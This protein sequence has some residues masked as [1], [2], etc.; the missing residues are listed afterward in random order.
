[1]RHAR[2]AAGGDANATTIEFR[3]IIPAPPR[4]AADDKTGT[5]R[6]ADIEIS[7]IS[8]EADLAAAFDIRREVFC[9]EQGVSEEEEID[10]LDAECR[11]Y[12]VRTGD[13]AVATARTRTI[14]SGETKIE[15]VAVLAAYRRC[16][17]GRALMECVISDIGKSPMTLNAQ[18]R[19][20][21]FYAR[22]GFVAEGEIFDEAGI[23]H[24]RM[25]LRTI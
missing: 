21:E 24:R 13:L 6:V 2:T 5:D 7:Q 3:S 1:M 18:L 16:G 4:P 14:A 19:T 20:V 22:L 12:L 15:R 10:G 25:T 23:P 11:H 17:V 9:R 8:G